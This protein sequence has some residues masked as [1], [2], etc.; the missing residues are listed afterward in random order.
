MAT[1]G[2]GKR[3]FGDPSDMGLTGLQSSGRIL[4]ITPNDDADLPGGVCRGIWSG[5]SGTVN[6]VDFTGAPVE[7]F[8]IFPGFNPIVV[9]RVLA[10]G[11]ATNLWA[12]Y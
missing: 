12:M 11:T 2:T 10:G 4:K 5:T 9:Q 6:F 7:D 8:P 3:K 1:I